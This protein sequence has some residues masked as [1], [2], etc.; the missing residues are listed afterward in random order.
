MDV[1]TRDKVVQNIRQLMADFASK[2]PSENI[3][4][5]QDL[6]EHGEWGEAFDLLCTQVYEYELAVSQEQYALIDQTGGLM[7]LESTGWDYLRE[8]VA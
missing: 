7:G 3:T 8:L 4:D 6:I 5:A 1:E 2:L